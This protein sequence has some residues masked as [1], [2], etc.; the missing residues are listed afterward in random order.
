MID[1]PADYRE[2][3]PELSELIE[4]AYPVVESAAWDA[5]GLMLDGE[6][7]FAVLSLVPLMV[8]ANIEIPMRLAEWAA[9]FFEVHNH[10]F[11]GEL[12]EYAQAST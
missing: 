12:I 10:A 4:L 6:D 11:A 1:I 5:L 7:E 3:N 8:A 9:W 2:A